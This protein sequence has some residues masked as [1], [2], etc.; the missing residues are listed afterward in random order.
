MR[1]SR[2]L[3]ATAG[4][5]RASWIVPSTASHAPS[6]S[7]STDGTGR[8]LDVPLVEEV[9]GQPLGQVA[10]DVARAPSPRTGAGL[11]QAPSGTAFTRSVNW[12]AT[13]AVAVGD[14]GHA[15]HRTFLSSA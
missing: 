1:V 6:G 5:S 3:S 10:H 13:V 8:A 15:G 7:S 11:A 12:A 4:S 2:A 9:A 14:L